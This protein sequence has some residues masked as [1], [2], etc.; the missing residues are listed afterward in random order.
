MKTLLTAS[1]LPQGSI[2]NSECWK[3]ERKYRFTASRFQLISERQRNHD[4]FAAQLINP[5]PF[6][7]RHVEHGLKYEPIALREYKKIM[8]TRKTPVKVLGPV[9][10]NPGKF[11]GL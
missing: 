11:S 10:R 8:L 7:S 4:K 5:K 9:S 2:S 3:K 6:S 1:N